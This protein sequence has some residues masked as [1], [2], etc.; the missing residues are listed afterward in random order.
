M[1]RVPLKRLLRHTSVLVMLLSVPMVLPSF[2][3]GQSGPARGSRDV[4]FQA[5]DGWTLYATYYPPEG[6]PSAPVPGLVVIFL[7]FGCNSLWG[8]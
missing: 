8:K 4:S 7:S 3:Q 1:N 5:E 6:D 2:L